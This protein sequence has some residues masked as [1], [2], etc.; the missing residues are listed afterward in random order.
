MRLAMA[1]MVLGII[2][3]AGTATV[4]LMLYMLGFIGH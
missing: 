1:F 2:A 3:V 4:M